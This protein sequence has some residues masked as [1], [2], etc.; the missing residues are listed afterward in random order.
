M[1]TPRFALVTTAALGLSSALNFLSLFLW[2]RLLDPHDFGSYALASATALLLNAVLFEWLRIVAARTLYDPASETMTDPAQADAIFAIAVPMVGL[3][4]AAGGLL[5]ALG[6]SISG[7]RP[8]WIPLIALF[9]LSEMALAMVNVVS[10]VR[11]E[12]WQF[13]QS[14]VVRSV[15]AI[16]LSLLLVLLFDLGGLGIIAGTVA[17]QVLT[18]AVIIARSPFWRALRLGRH[19]RASRADV[20]AVLTLGAPL[21]VSTGLAYGVGIADRYILNATLGTGAV[22]HYAA[23]A[24]ILQKTLGFLLLAINITAYPALVRAYEDNGAEPARRLLE[25]NFVMQLALGLPVV[26]ACIVLAPGLANL[27]LGP[28]FRDEGALL[29]PWIGASALLRLLTTYHLMMVFQLLRRMKLMLVAP[30]VTLSLVVPG[31]IYAATNFGLVGMAIASLIAQAVSYGVCT[32]IAKR[33]FSFDLVSKDV[34]KVVA[35]SAVMGALLLPAAAIRDPLPVAAICAGAGAAYLVVLL[36]LRL[37]R[38]APIIGWAA[39]RWRRS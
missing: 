13:F 3:L 22:G 11:L 16:A 23:T 17:A 18:A 25:D 27:L 31:G 33:L 2:V 24:D 12:P 32:V 26:V 28:T 29:M 14:M 15:L 5:W 38:A 34:L 7:V 6:V 30:L 9:T 39:A 8:G 20:R 36:A 19:G 1:S 4:L 10:R 37:D 21:I 35:A